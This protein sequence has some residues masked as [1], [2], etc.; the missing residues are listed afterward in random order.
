V[1]RLLSWLL[2]GLV[3]VAGGPRS[4]WAGLS[5]QLPVDAG[6]AAAQG[7]EGNRAVTNGRYL[8][9]AIDR[10]TA[11]TLCNN[12]GGTDCTGELRLLLWVGASQV[13]IECLDASGADCA[14]QV[15]IPDGTTRGIYIGDGVGGYTL[16]VAMTADGVWAF[17]PAESCGVL[18]G[19]ASLT[20]QA[21]DPAD[22]GLL[23]GGNNENLVCAELATPGADR[24]LK[25]TTANEWNFTGTVTVDTDLAVTGDVSA[26]DGT[27]TG[28]LTVSN[29]GVDFP[30]SD[31]NPTCASGNHRLFADASE[32]SLK[33][34]NDGALFT[35]GERVQALVWA[36]NDG[37]AATEY[38]RSDRDATL[39]CRSSDTGSEATRT[40]VTRAGLLK[41]LRCDSN[42]ALGAGDTYTFTARINGSNTGVTC[43]MTGAAE[44]S[45]T[46]TSNTAA[47]APGDL[48][49]IH[50][51]A[52][53]AAADLGGVT[54]SLENIF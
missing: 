33:G 43:T 28:Q 23:R 11:V 47:T 46:D 51:A 21:A 20:S 17:Q 53:N 32:A 41:N 49:A 25:V 18:T 16:C 30:A 22:T 4:T 2:C 39:T 26:T 45:C 5:V 14:F 9:G 10:T 27:F 6:E 50:K 35:V 54:C 29:L 7:L 34:C 19:V 37:V 3:L 15:Y 48:I 44:F 12:S 31:T 40:M 1:L 52:S 24:C 13:N 42:S 38:L 36:C 8:T